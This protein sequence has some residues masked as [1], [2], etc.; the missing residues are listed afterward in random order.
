MDDSTHVTE[1]FEKGGGER[2]MKKLPEGIESQLGKWFDKGVELSGGEWQAVALGRAFARDT[3]RVLVLDEPTAALDA[4]AE[5]AV[6][7]RFRELTRG[8]T[9]L[10]ISHRLPTVRMADRIVVLEGG[11]LRESGTHDELVKKG[12]L[13]ASLFELQASGYR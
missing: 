13:Y 2:L 11:E 9:A 7:E 10:L 4:A 12:G 5:H 1:A 8:K 6:F 3:A